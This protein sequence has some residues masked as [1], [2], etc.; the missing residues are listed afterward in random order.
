[1][2]PHVG[3]GDECWVKVLGDVNIER[4]EGR[5]EGREGGR[6]RQIRILIQ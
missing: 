5:K 6:R 4:K 1:M 3:W 2:F